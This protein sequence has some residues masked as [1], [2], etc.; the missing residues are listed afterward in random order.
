MAQALDL[1]GQRFGKLVARR[2]NGET[3]REGHVWECLCDCG[4]TKSVATTNLRRG[5]VKSCGCSRGRTAGPRQPAVAPTSVRP[6]AQRKMSSRETADFVN[7]FRSPRQAQKAYWQFVL[8]RQR[9]WHR[10]TVLGQ[11]APWT[12]DKVLGQYRIFNLQRELDR[13]TIEWIKELKDHEAG[14]TL[15]TIVFRRLNHLEAWRRDVGWIESLADVQ[16]AVERLA[17]SHA[18]GLSIHQTAWQTK[19]SPETIS[20]TANGAFDVREKITT[21]C[22]LDG[23][24]E[25]LWR[26][27]QEI[28]GIGP[29]IA[30]QVALDLRYVHPNLSDDT[31]AF[32]GPG[33][34]IANLL[35]PDLQ[36]D[37]PQEIL[38]W[39][40]DT[41]PRA[42]AKVCWEGKPRY[43]LADVE[44][45]LCEFRR[46]LNWS[47][48]KRSST[49]TSYD[50]M[51]A[52]PAPAPETPA[53][54]QVPEPTPGRFRR[55]FR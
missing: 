6:R 3:G 32:A 51:N 20:D 37:D 10:R 30:W 26:V 39:L 33:T 1:T 49:D 50:F 38:R 54:W 14:H 29:W 34:K 17:A 12:D 31:W 25:P 28:R 21:A 16:P 46:Y 24:L 44:N 40:R 18:A 15:N 22:S 7:P 48:G 53:G 19:S 42:L 55:L 23:S 5:R 11:P 27:L 47:V 2:W 36:D 35:R 45:G 4:N 13:C 8:E 9:I 52:R 41:Q 43:T